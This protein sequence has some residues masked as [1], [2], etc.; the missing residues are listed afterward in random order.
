MITR[1]L[2]S[3]GAFSTNRP[4]K[5]EG[6]QSSQRQ[7]W[8]VPAL[9]NLGVSHIARRGDLELMGH[10]RRARAAIRPTGSDATHWVG[11]R[12]GSSRTAMQLAASPAGTG[13]T[14]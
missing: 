12:R 9:R 2:L 7:R 5:I 3:G 11:S 8:H 4:G 13:R 6:I 1:Q 10:R 14:T